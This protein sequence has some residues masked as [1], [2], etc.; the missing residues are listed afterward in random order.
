MRYTEWTK[1][2]AKSNFKPETLFD[3]SFFA[4]GATQ[5]IFVETMQPGN[6]WIYKIPAS[7]GR[8]LPFRPGFRSMP[9]WNRYLNALQVVCFR[10]PSDLVDWTRHQDDSRTHPHPRIRRAVKLAA[11]LNARF[12]AKC[13]DC[14]L[15]PYFRRGH[16]LGFR[17]MLNVLRTISECG[18]DDVLLPYRIDPDLA[19]ILRVGEKVHHY[20]GPVLIQRRA[21]QFIERSEGLESFNWCEIIA[22]QHQLWRKGIAL[23][24]TAEV[25][26]PSNWALLDGRVLLGDTGSLTTNYNSGRS[27]LIPEV[28][29]NRERF[30]LRYLQGTQRKLAVEYLAFIRREINGERLAQLWRVDL[31]EEQVQSTSG[32]KAG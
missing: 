24:D 6:G 31:K 16:A 19:T 20:R 26:G 21:E 12:F 3:L 8:I 13:G 11:S 7:F 18:L 5:H 10:L 14:V 22:A 25:L 23:S 28:L 9:P 27:A 2:H 1:P 32:H 17:E 4:T 29:N 30:I 15:A